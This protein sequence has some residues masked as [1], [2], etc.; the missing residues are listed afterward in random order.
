VYSFGRD[1]DW[2][3]LYPSGGRSLRLPSY[4][5]QRERYWY[6]APSPSARHRRSSPADGE[7]AVI[8]RCAPSAIH[9]GTYFWNADLTADA[10]PFVDHDPTGRS[11]APLAVLI[12]ATLAGAAHVYGTGV[13]GLEHVDVQEPLVLDDDPVAVQLVL[14][15]GGIGTASFQLLSRRPQGAGKAD[16]A[17]TRH[18]TGTVDVGGV[19]RPGSGKPMSVA[20]LRA[21]A[22]REGKGGQFVDQLWQSSGEALARVKVPSDE[23]RGDSPISPAV[24]AACLEVLAGVRFDGEAPDGALV[25]VGIGR[26]HVHRALD[27]AAGI[28]CH[29]V[30]AADSERDSIARGD[31]RLV[32]ETGEIAIEITGIRLRTAPADGLSGALYRIGWDLQPLDKSAVPASPSD[33]RGA[34]LIFCDRAGIGEA[35][36]ARLEGG[37]ERCIRVFAGDGYHSQGTTYQLH[38]GRRD[39]FTQLMRE[40][41]AL[42][43]PL[44]GVAHLWSLDLLGADVA[45]AISGGRS[46]ESWAG[47]LHLVQA[48]AE[49]GSTSTPRLWLVTAGVQA[50]GPDDAVISV[51]QSPLWGLGSAIAGEH[52]EFQ[53][54]RLD[55]SGSPG[56]AEIEALLNEIQS[57]AAETQVALRGGARY[58]ARMVR[59]T[60]EAEAAPAAEA[61]AESIAVS[62]DAPCRAVCQP[63]VLDSV[64]FEA[65]PRRAPAP[66]EIEIEVRAVGLNYVNVLS[67]LGACPGYPKGMGPL[68]TECTGRV[69]RVGDGVSDWHEGDEV[70]AIA[71]ECLGRHAVTD[72]RLAAPKPATLTFEEAATLPIAFVT[73]HYAL[74]ELGRL[75][76]GERVLIHS[77]SGGVGLAAVQVAQQAGAEI[78]ATAGTEEK[79]E[80]L[81]SL[82]IRSVMDSRSTAFAAD[83][84]AATGGEGVDVVLNSL[85]GA[86]MAL[87]FDVLRPYG[88]FL[89]LGRRDIHDDRQIGLAPFR[90]GLS[91]VAID[92]DRMSAERPDLVGSLLKEVVRGVD[93]GRFQPIRSKTFDGPDVSDAFKYLAGA[94]HIGKA[95]IS[96]QPQSLPVHQARRDTTDWSSGTY[97]ITGGLGSLGLSVAQWMVKKGARHLVLL[98]RRGASAAAA[99]AIKTMEDAGASI[100]VARADVSREDEL[101][102]VL[103][104][105]EDSM[106]PLRGIMHAAAV[107]DDGILLQQDSERCRAVMAPK[108]TGTWN[109]HHLTEGRPLDFFVMFSSVASFLAS[110]GTGNYAAANAFLDAFADYR[111][112]LGRPATTI[113]W[114]GWAEMGLAAGQPERLERLSERGLKNFSEAEGLAALDTVLR[115]NSARVLAMRFD[116]QVWCA[117][118]DLA[119]PTLLFTHLLGEPKTAVPPGDDSGVEEL[120]LKDSLLAVDPGPRRRSFMEAHLRGQVARVLRLAPARIDINKP[121]RTM[122][123]DSLMGLELRNRLEG[124]AG[125]AIPATLIWNYPTVTGLAAQLAVRLGVALDAEPSVP[126]AQETAE[127]AAQENDADLAGLLSE[128]EELSEDDARRLLVE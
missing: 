41:S 56:D 95:V 30:R 43:H 35:L 29:A 53:C 36:A 63:G 69:A 124:Q 127:V 66:G 89:D 47:A 5:W 42:D 58:V 120:N 28:W 123:L 45:P 34:W 125:I 55:L 111:R 113:N 109:L 107:L 44:R 33:K 62:S 115:S 23:P 119:T 82:G 102:G 121:F 4:P 21:R 32:D 60:P 108:V 51:A 68:G 97:L 99:S 46:E 71:R 50:A 19:R 52:P 1:V 74:I 83:L 128:I 77:A 86:A 11:V 78:F 6:D 94:Q 91:Y 16:H 31:V 48:L 7:H 59:W 75:R 106:P 15:P 61:D 54:T 101:A 27:S 76:A 93:G 49:C 14:S 65:A 105:V 25:P 88:R 39:E 92:V 17:W 24:L 10:L 26:L 104:Q 67:A 12:E 64:R 90:K 126:M 79:R 73:A 2:A 37:G 85:G 22:M 84:M 40:I 114:G 57:Q 8:G 70:V 116:A 96:L 20:E 112:S 118:P 13:V 9:A 122:G 3:R 103:A 117:A 98:G 38:A 100:L 18:L 72:A 80:F 87:G 81:R 110:A